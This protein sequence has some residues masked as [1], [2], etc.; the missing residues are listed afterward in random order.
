MRLALLLSTGLN[1]LTWAL[2]LWF[3]LPRLTTSPFFA[4]HYTIYFGVDQIGAPWKLLRLPLLGL[5]ILVVNAV[6]S[7][8]LYQ[9]DRLASA[10]TLALT[11][12][13][14]ALILFVTFL[15]VLLNL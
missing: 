9:K 13:L 1:L 8:R 7:V 15:T 2:S 3:V 10:A 6:L 5:G 11:L 12:L 14:E 4:L